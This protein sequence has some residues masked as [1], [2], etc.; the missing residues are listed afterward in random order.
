MSNL[1]LRE[2]D[3]TTIA[4]IGKL[5]FSPLSVVGGRGNRLIEEGGRSLLD[6]SGSAGPAILGYGHPA[7]VEAVAAS[8]RDMAGASLLLYPNEPAVSLAE[9]LL[10]ITPGNGER[11][12]WFGHSGSDAN[13]CAVRVLQ[14]AT[15]RSR[16]ISF[17]GSY[18]GNLSG[19]MGISGHTAMTHT[20]PRPGVLLLPYP[21]PFRPQFSAEAVLAL[22]DYQ[23]ETTCPP[24]QVAAVFIE[25]LMSD[26]GL[27]V[28]PPGFLKALQE[29]CRRHGIRIVVDE[30]KVGLAR[31][32]MMH[33]FQHEG[34]TPDLVVFGKGIGGG[35]PL[36]AVIGPK[37]IMD[38]APAFAL[39]TTAGNPV[40]ASAGNAVLKT[41]DREGLVERSARVGTLFSEALRA[42]AAKHEIIGDVRG[43]GL[44]IGVDLVKDRS[45][46]E[47]VPATTTAKIIY[48]GYELGAAFTYV[49][50]KANVLEFM[51]PLTLIEDEVTEGAA[52]VD[53]AI[54]DVTAGKVSDAD[55]VS[56]MM[57]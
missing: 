4:Q 44:A 23:F 50:L 38:H 28:P 40:A 43:R 2:R 53:Q 3:A 12:V 30:V 29:R 5:R 22:L 34:L 7:I 49:G 17:I 14:A 52:I 19:S 8:I 45:T 11:R 57:W 56:F 54:A 24:H 20:L 15:G 32:G 26:G 1:S 36:S 9:R 47:P 55:V 35:L 46:R 33:C 41:I 27:I 13:D 16:F 39:Q 31:S 6:L 37:E 10:A 21:D 25:P 51:P 48:R 18:H 42:L